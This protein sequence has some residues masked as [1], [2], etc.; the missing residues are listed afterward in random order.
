MFDTHSHIQ[1]KIFDDTRD[2]VIRN[3]KQAEVE[4]IIAVGTDLISSRD[5]ISVANKYPEVFAAVGI[6]PHHVFEHFQGANIKNNLL[7]IEALLSEKQV[8]AVGETGI[9]K[10]QYQKTKYK[11]YQITNNFIELQKNFFTAQ[12]KLAIKHDKA[13]II[14]NRKAPKET[15]EVLSQEWSPELEGRSVFHMCE[16]N[17]KLLEFA[18]KHNVYISFGGDITYDLEKQ[19]FLKKVPL[20]LLVLETDSPFFTPEPL[21]SEGS[22]LNSPSSLGIIVDN[23][24]TIYSEDKNKIIETTSNNSLNLFKLPTI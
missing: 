15:L 18:L 24:S 3:A 22:K 6:H 21:K 5:A 14:H 20:E 23:I 7:E 4:K 1:F 16:P 13:L 12:I 2:Q 9:D 10:H 17:P 11:N 8:V 19:D